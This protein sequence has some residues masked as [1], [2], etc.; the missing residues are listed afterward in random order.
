[1][2]LCPQQ[3]QL[4][5]LQDFPWSRCSNQLFMSIMW[6]D[7]ILA[8]QKTDAASHD[9][10]FLPLFNQLTDWKTA[11]GICPAV[12]VCLCVSQVCVCTA[13]GQQTGREDCGSA[14]VSVISQ[15]SS[16]REKRTDRGLTEITA[17]TSHHTH[18]LIYSVWLLNNQSSAPVLQFD[19]YTFETIHSLYQHVQK[20][21]PIEE[22][23]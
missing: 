8:N 4:F 2:C 16:C 15:P 18:T 7:D 11:A 20:L 6:S 23:K 12:C 19:L 17:V 5:Q 21:L 14:S 1:M 22:C 13:G 3:M 9:S 10:Q